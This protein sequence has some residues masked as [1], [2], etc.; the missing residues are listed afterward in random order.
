MEATIPR[1]SASFSLRSD[2]LAILR[3]KAR[4]SHCTLDAYIENVLIDDAYTDEPNSTTRQ[5][6]MEAKTG[7]R[8]P[9]EVYDNVETMMKDLLEA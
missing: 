1:E 7:K 8:D 5:A 3:Q 4:R 2:V 6:I 9:S